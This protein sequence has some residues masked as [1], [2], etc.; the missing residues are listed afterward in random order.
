MGNKVDLTDTFKRINEIKKIVD[1]IIAL[2]EILLNKYDFDISK[3]TLNE[4]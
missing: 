4:D 3:E 2:Q 1:K